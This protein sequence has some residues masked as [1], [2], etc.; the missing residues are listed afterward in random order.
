M[1]SENDCG[2]SIVDCDMRH[3]SEFGGAAVGY[4]SLERNMPA[5]FKSN[6]Y[7]TAR[8]VQILMTVIVIP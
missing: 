5:R 3:E 2:C 6:I 1:G 4:G 7:R 8:I